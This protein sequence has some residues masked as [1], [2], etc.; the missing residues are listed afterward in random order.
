M[1][2]L[3]L[4]I[5]RGFVPA[6]ES[7]SG[8]L[9]DYSGAAAAFSVRRLLS[10]YTGACMRVREDSG[11]TETDIGF[12]SNG[13]LDTA[14]IATHCGTANGYV[15]KWYG[16]ESS[17]GTGSG[18]DAEQATSG[19]Q[20]QIYNGS[21]VI[22]NNGVSALQFDNTGQ[23]EFFF[24]A[25]S[26]VKT[27][28]SVCGNDGTGFSALLGT[29]TSS[30]TADR[31]LRQIS[32]GVWYL[33]NTGPEDWYKEANGDAYIDGSQVTGRPSG[34]SQQLIFA[35]NTSPSATYGFSSVSNRFNNRGWYGKIQ[36]IIIYE[37]TDY[38]DSTNRT[39]IESSIND[40]YSI[41]T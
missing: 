13:D 2:G 25:V 16:Q 7:F 4:G 37:N 31:S 6:G 41:Y 39:G 40:Y 10:G 8:L 36:E 34:G 30:S 28:F 18:N 3:G 35:W 12:D 9:D 26:T 21:S 19:T 27:V 33:D 20:P 29:D 15:T 14:A 38:S 22:T 17:G 24:T 11:D 32:G 5:N 1:L 23:D